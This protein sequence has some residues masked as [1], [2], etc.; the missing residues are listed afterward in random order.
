MTDRADDNPEDWADRRERGDGAARR[1]MSGAPAGTSGARS[2]AGRLAWTW[3]LVA[4]LLALVTFVNVMTMLDDA[5]RRGVHMPLALPLTLET[6]STVAGLTC[7][8]IIAFMVR[9]APPT[10]APLWRTALLHLGG[11][12]AF[13][14]AHVALMSLFRTVLFALAG[15]HYDWSASELPYEYRKDVLTYVVVGALFWLTSRPTPAPTPALAAVEPSARATFDI[16]DGAALLRVPVGEI[17]AARGA[18]NYVE[19]ALEDGRRPLMRAALG[20]VEA[21]LAAQGFVRTHRSWLVNAARVRALNPAGSG[22]FRLDLG[23]G[24]TAPLSRRYPE[25]LARLRGD[26]PGAQRSA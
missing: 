21:Q 23:C 15:H 24:V 10:R 1:G 20:S 2:D 8:T 7:A 17:L 16:R 9:V 26:E 4:G 6:T 25:A 14:V 13:S 12:I 5:R 19:F 3:L 11:S 22:D 18:G